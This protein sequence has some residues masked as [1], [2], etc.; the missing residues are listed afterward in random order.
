MIDAPAKVGEIATWLSS[1]DIISS[2]AE[3]SQSKAPFCTALGAEVFGRNS[4]NFS[5][6]R[7]HWLQEL[8]SDNQIE[9]PM[10]M[11]TKTIYIDF[12]EDGKDVRLKIN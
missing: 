10:N 9:S 5:Q 6:F 8:H 1:A 2:S 12:P 7:D 3:M 4:A 11:F